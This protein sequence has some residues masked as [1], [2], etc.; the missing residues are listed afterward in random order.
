MARAVRIPVTVKMRR[1]GTTTRST[2]PS[3]ARLVEDAGAAAVTVH[4]RTAK[5]SYTG[6]GRL[7]LRRA[8]R[9]SASAFRCSASATASSREQIVERLRRGRERRARRAAACCAIR[10]SWRR[11]RTCSTAGRCATVVA[12]RSAAQFLLE[13]IDLLLNERVDER[14][15][16]PPHGAGTADRSA[17]TPGRAG[18]ERWVINKLRALCTWYTKGFDGGSHLRIAVNAAES[19]DELQ[20][21]VGRFFAEPLEDA[22]STPAPTAGQAVGR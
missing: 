17:P 1:A 9:R 16:L 19:L 22:A 5:Q 10:G 20:E 3:V 4:G 18:R 15:G 7:G 6:I 8:R 13:Y 14:A 12:R 2:R 21:V 11:R